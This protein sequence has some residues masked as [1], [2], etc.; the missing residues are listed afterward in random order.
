M[1]N[2]SIAAE[3]HRERERERPVFF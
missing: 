1:C 3:Y 2:I